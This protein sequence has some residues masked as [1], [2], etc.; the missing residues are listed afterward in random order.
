MDFKELLEKYQTLLIENNSLKEEIMSLKAQLGIIE[1]QVVPGEIPNYISEPEIFNNEF[2]GKTLQLNVNSKSDSVEKIKL[3]MSLFKGRDDVYAKRWENKK[4]GTSGYSPVCLH[5]WK[6]EL[7]AKPKGKCAGCAFKEYA[8]LNEMV[9]DDHLRGR[10]N[11]VAGIYP[12]CLD[13]TCYFL[14]IDFDDG[15]WQKDISVIRQVCT[16]F[17]IPIAVE[18]SRSGKGAHAWFFF[19]SPISAALARRFGSALLTFSMSKRHEITF[20]SYDRFFP[21]QDTM[22]KGGLGNLI[23]LPLQK[24]ARKANNSEFID[25][26]FQPYNDQWAF[27]ATIHKLSENDVE[28][29]STKLCHGNELGV[30]KKDEEENQKPWETSKV[31]LLKNDF[32]QDVEIVKANM[33][34]IPKAGISQKALNH[35]KRLAAFKNPEFYRAQAMRMPTTKIPRIISCS[36]ETAEYLCLPRGCEADLK[37]IFEE[38]GMAV[39]YIDKTNCGKK[40]DVE[41]NGSLR[42]EQPLAFDKLLRHDIGVLCG[43]TAFGKTVVAIKLI[44]ERKVNTLILVDKVNLVPQWKERLMKFLTINE[45]LPD[46]DINEGKKR[47]R[48]KANSI[49]GQIG[50][51]K[52]SLS[53]VIDIAI[54]QSLNRM[55][56]VKEYVKNYG[57]IIVDEC[58]HVSAFSFEKIL[59]STNAKYVY[60]LTATPT[61]KDGHHPIIFMQCG[62]IRYRDD[63]KKQAEKRPFEHYIIPRFT[64]LRVPLNKDESDVS[65]QELYSEI[66][67]NEMRNQLIV[68]DVV[69]SHEDGRNC[70]VL[71]ERT[72]H[73]KLL[74]KKINNRIPDVISLTGGMGTKETREKMKRII[75]TPADKQLTL[76]AT[77]KYIGEGFDE[78]RLDTLFL[79]M[80]ISWKGTLQQ[81]AGRLHRLFKNKNEVQIYDY[82][83]I[84]VRMLEKMYNKRLTG[85]AS[86]GYKAKGE[87]FAAE[88]INIIFDKSN[89]LPV[90]TNDIVNAAREILIVSPF[91]TKKRTLQMLQ[92]LRVVLQNK[93]RVI[94]VTRPVED[95]KEKNMNALQGTL[96]LLED[97]GVSVV[98]RSN[99]HQKFAVID[100]RIVWYGSINLL[101]F[102]SAE[103]SIMRLESPNIAYELIKSIGERQVS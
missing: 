27:L 24:A 61:R 62:S 77:G 18:R 102:G 50:A 46:E 89:F 32:P 34:F 29:L 15:E 73:V 66:V 11:F 25:E 22:P 98:F 44:A 16:E 69:K 72:A 33:L 88:S 12:L 76:V 20:K 92:H 97:A 78:P 80:P 64:S 63:A 45:T 95:F 93:V 21:N 70:I 37:A 40:I 94:V 55:G 26:N 60:G 83:D 86:I 84:H 81:Y 4:K 13:E 38:L 96:K 5:E 87:S 48:K 47:G 65:I 71:T 57:M 79:A 51:G 99:I 39:N 7:C 30:L 8:V 43:T 36:E 1:P 90:Y 58:H 19:K 68:D 75:N 49:I 52:D 56:E 6:S 82:V 2:A 74:A 10:D 91:I 28:M 67:I 101:S 35:L 3:F 9:I 41:F 42:D 85:Y 31:K 59:K 53:G 54:M 14:A 100:Q 103:E 23:A 17:N